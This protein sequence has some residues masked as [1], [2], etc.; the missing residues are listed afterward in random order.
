[1]NTHLD[2][3]YQLANRL[4]LPLLWVLFLCSL[5]LSAMH[6]TWLWAIVI[7]LPTALIPS[8]FLW[9]MPN[10]FISRAMVAVALMVFSAL[11]IHQ[12]AGV[13]E[14]HFGIFVLLAFLLCYRDWKVILVAA[15]VIAL[16]HLSFNY[17]QE[18]G[19]GVICFTKPGL[20]TV[21]LHALYVVVESAVLAYLAI[22]LYHD[23]IQAVELRNRVNAMMGADNGSIDL[24]F[25][26]DAP[27][28]SAG[29]A[30]QLMMDELRRAIADVRDGTIEI[31][32]ASE[33]IANNNIALAER[34][35]QQSRSLSE[36]AN[37]IAHITL[38]V[39]N[40]AAH[41]SHADALAKTATQVA[42]RGGLEV[43][44]VVATMASISKSSQKIVDIISVIDSIAFQ[45]NI[46]ALNAAV[47]AA[48]AGEQGRGFAVVAGEVR[49]LAQRSALAAKEIKDLINTSAEEVNVGSSLVSQAGKT[50]EDVVANIRSVTETMA[51]IR[52]DAREQSSSIEQVNQAVLEI[53]A[54]T[55][56]NTAM[57]E[58]AASISST[59]NAQ[60]QR[61]ISVVRVFKLPQ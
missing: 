47:E 10:A 4:M 15:L 1:M 19:Y 32:F 58:E 39:K 54:V 29:K 23:A 41:T 16:H 43:G 51:E 53:G 59:F 44:R 11:F 37:S 17:L 34:T 36:T 35:E 26:D 13:T 5:G 49:N 24:R 6:D 14:F 52:E 22:L 42:E 55:K 28:S 57:V 33:Q 31:N 3:Y 12:A 61:L 25:A 21:L 45:T 46:L 56:Q 18:W 50:M 48:R 60:V 7:G 9:K 30:L 20:G 40:S 38:A 8:I 2:H 27:S